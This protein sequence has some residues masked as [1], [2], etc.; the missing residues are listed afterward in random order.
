MKKLSKKIVVISLI[1]AFVL[2]LT[3]CG[4]NINSIGLPTELAL[5]KGETELLAVEYGAEDEATE[6]KIAEAAAKLTLEWSSS[7]ESVATVGQDGLVTAVG[8]GTANITVGI[9]DANIQS[10]CDVTVSVPLESIKTD[11][12]LALIINGTDGA[13]LNAVLEPADATDVDV[14]YESSDE[15]VATVDSNGKVTA[16]GAGECEIIAT[17]T[18]YDGKTVE[19]KTAVKVDVAPESLALEDATLTIGYS[20][21]LTAA[22]TGENVTIGQEFS[23]TSSNTAI[24]TVDEVGGIKAEGI[25][26][27]TVTVSNEVGQSATC[28][29]TVKNIV[30]AYCGQEG[31]GSNN[32]EKKAA[33]E[34]AAAEAARIAAEQAAQQAAA[35]QGGGG[36]GA[37]GG[38]GGPVSNG[39]G[40]VG[41]NHYT[42]T[43]RDNYTIQTSPDGHGSSQTGGMC[44]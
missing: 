38:A 5:D 10:V 25:G 17:A 4:V 11:E 33:D 40:T 23:W 26:T 35:A 18:S 21:T 43:G 34:A 28:T 37:S 27:A 42:S 32:C 3:A 6:E 7:D 24:V 44:P 13:D 12:S 15:A 39:D 20:D 9:K 41:E 1:F 36:A 8:A 29:V 30:C 31:H 16:V 14:K 19:A 2:S 22:V